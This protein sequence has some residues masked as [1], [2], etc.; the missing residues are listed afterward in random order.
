M[1]KTTFNYAVILFVTTILSSQAQ[2]G[3]GTIDPKSLLDIPASNTT[4]PAN[5]DGILIPRVDNFPSTDPTIDQNSMIVFLNRDITGYLKGFHYWDHSRTDWI[6]FVQEEW[7]D[8][9]NGSGDNLIFA[10]QAKIAGTDMVITDDGRIGFGTDDPVERFEFKGPGDND[11]QIT[12]ANANP[13]NFI[14]Y[15]TGGTIASPAAF[16]VA[17]QEIGS[18]IV[19]T[20][21][22]SAIREPGGF[23][24]Y[25]DG[26]A[27]PG[28]TP[29]RFVISTTPSGSVSQQERIIVRSTGFVGL[30]TP[31]PSQV[32]DVNGNARVR[33]LGA[34]AVYSNATGVLST[35]GP[36][37]FALGKVSATGTAAKIS[38][39]TV[40]RVSTGV[41]Q[42][43]F[44]T[45]QL[46][47]NYLIQLSVLNCSGC[48]TDDSI[49][50]YYSNQ[51]TTGFR[52]VIG[53]NDNGNTA[54]VPSNL[55]FMFSAISF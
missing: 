34:G 14:L 2:V 21:D 23:R 52:V 11:F 15:N 42:V 19:K 41:Y 30:G 29:S 3:I 26:L 8:G 45:A 28:S 18:F 43:T 51:T 6:P 1:K 7:E 13:P 27:S 16:T 50:I 36:Q 9:T 46:D 20:H 48:G 53:A 32:L 31:D 12:S 24:Y 35:S 47:A 5:T 39:A 10:K 40:S 37:T 17:D 49:G 44:T 38:G 33:G 22:G 4:A 55:E 54:K 25:I